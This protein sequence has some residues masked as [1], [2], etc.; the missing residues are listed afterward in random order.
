[1]IFAICP[2][3]GPW[4]QDMLERLH[5]AV[6]SRVSAPAPAAAAGVKTQDFQHFPHYMTAELVGTLVGASP[7][8]TKM[9]AVAQHLVSLGCVSPNERSAPPPCV[10]DWI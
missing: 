8:R 10:D 9:H 5:S 1:M 2:D 3:Q 6:H 7:M 4:P